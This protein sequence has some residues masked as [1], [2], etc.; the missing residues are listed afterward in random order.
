MALGVFAVSIIIRV[1]A[2]VFHL[3]AGIK[4]LPR[5][6]RRLTICTSPI[7]TPELVPGLQPGQDGFTLPDILSDFHASRLSTTLGDKLVAY[8]TLLP[9]AFL[10]F[11][12]AWLYRI[13]LKSTAWF[14]W[15]LAFLGDETWLARRPGLIHNRTIRNLTAKTSIAASITTVILFF[16]ANSPVGHYLFG[17]YPFLTVWF[18]P[19]TVTWSSVAPWQLL[20]LAVAVLTIFLMFWVDSAI[21]D[22]EYAEARQEAEILATTQGQFRW[23]ERVV[24]L[25]RVLLI[26]FMLIAF[27]HAALYFNQWGCWFS[28]PGNVQGW[29]QWI[30]GDNMP[31][32]TC[33]LKP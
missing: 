21:R 26:I 13:T 1:S 28:L 32:A 30:Y 2:T 6:F 29:A 15:P 20:T 19:F 22:H 25:R 10:W 17:Q 8:V 12:P 16:A 9:M 5:N 14:W 24:R 31:L 23:I 33:A 4:Q 18:Y 3:K 7:Q 11:F 27:G